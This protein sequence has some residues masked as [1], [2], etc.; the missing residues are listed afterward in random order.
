MD[1]ASRSLIQA[2]LFD[3][4]TRLEHALAGSLRDRHLVYLL[5][6]VDSA[7]N[8]ISE[9][10]YGICEICNEEIEPDRLMADP[11]VRLCLDH[12]TVDQ[13]RALEEDLALAAETQKNLLPVRNQRMYGWEIE[14]HYEGAG[15]VSGDYCDVLAVGGNLYFLIG[16]I[17][18]KG[19][20]ASLL[21]AHLHATFRSLVSHDT[22]LE[23][24]ME[25][26]SRMFCESTLP[27]HFATLVL[28]KAAPTG[29]FEICNAGHNPPLIVRASSLELLEATALPLGMFCDERFTASS[30][31]LN[32]GEYLFLYTDGLSETFNERNEEYGMPRI[33]DLLTGHAAASPGEVIAA[34]LQS[35]QEFRAQAPKSDDLT[36]MVVHRSE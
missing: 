26:A 6:E 25:R 17:S 36:L 27:T 11:V 24:I 20:A 29:D 32:S 34:V 21:M 12:L 3:R 5:S 9:G 16:D 15:P 4:K 14:Y 30:G 8:R 2:Q 18:G 19:V 10:T 7:L 23:R 31:R 22:S 28:G 35:V 33:R 13:Q 1:D